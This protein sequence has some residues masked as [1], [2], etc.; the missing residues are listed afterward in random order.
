MIYLCGI[1]SINRGQIYGKFGI[2]PNESFKNSRTRQFLLS[3]DLCD[4]VCTRGVATG[5]SPDMT[6]I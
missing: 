2:F 3:I 4:M 5:S 6:T 1:K